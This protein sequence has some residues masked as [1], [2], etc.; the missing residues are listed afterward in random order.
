MEIQ[1]NLKHFGIQ[2][3]KAYVQNSNCTVRLE[4]AT[5]QQEND[6]KKAD[7]LKHYR[8]DWLPYIITFNI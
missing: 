6:K 4:T 1:L 8:E 3:A 2:N 5:P 7:P